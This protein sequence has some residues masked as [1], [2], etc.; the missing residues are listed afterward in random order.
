MSQDSIRE[1]RCSYYDTVEAFLCIQE[2][3]W[4]EAMCKGF[5]E[6]FTFSVDSLQIEVWKDCFRVLQRELCEFSQKYKNFYI[7]FEYALPYESG[8]RPDVILV[9][10]TYIVI[11]E[12]KKKHSILRA[13]CDQAIA[14]GRDI[15]EYHVASRNKV[16][17][18][19]LVVTE[20]HNYH[21]VYLEGRFCICSGDRLGKSLL[22]DVQGMFGPVPITVWLASKYEP[23]PTIVEAA[24]RIMAKEELP[25][26]RKVTST[27]I[28]DALARLESA[29]FYAKKHSKYML[30]F[31]TGVPGSGKTFLGLQFVYTIQEK[32]SSI[33]S[34]YLSGNGP[35]VRVLQD[36]LQSRAFVQDLH[37]V[38]Y[39]YCHYGARDFSSNV[40]VFDEG[41]RAW[42]SRRMQEKRQVTFS[43]PEIIL[44]LAEERLSWCFLLIL[45]GEGQ[46]IHV[47]ESSGLSLWRDALQSRQKKWE[48]ICPN[49]LHS[50]F[51]TSCYYRNY[52]DLSVSL[53]SHLAEDVSTYVNYIIAGKFVEARR[54]ADKI[55][56]DG[57]CMLVT[58]DI[59]AARSYCACR[60]EGQTSKRYGLIASSKASCLKKYGVDASYNATKKI[61]I[62]QWYNT[63]ATSGVSCCNMQHVATEFA[64]QGLELDFPLICWGNDMVWTGNCWNIPMSHSSYAKNEVY[65]YRSN[66]YRV[67]LTRGRDG[68]MIFIPPEPSFD[69]LY[70]ALLDAGIENLDT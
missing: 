20:M 45:V 33:K 66:S 6:A 34:V 26:I 64:C 61:N 10:D 65:L 17:L 11:L 21:K 18:T 53:R 25:Q 47:G 5:R 51:Q 59:E 41:Q 1:K 56:S 37:K 54:Y 27:C 30:S 35:L 9:S 16:V 48:V 23:L 24:R 12:F 8:R 43:E 67:L 15:K 14:Y 63:D 46:E 60:Y 58:R 2:N 4:I 36:S 22:H 68:F 70:A 49:K 39:E 28:P 13:D 57:F 42:D 38:E 29:A 62:A 19:Y 7:V 3:Q 55:K 32:D 40:I 52:L 50:L 69:K 44:R 31:V